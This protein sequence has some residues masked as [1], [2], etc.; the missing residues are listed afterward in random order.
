MYL[1]FCVI[2]Q[3][4]NIIF[5]LE[6]KNVDNKVKLLLCFDFGVFNAHITVHGC[7]V[8]SGSAQKF[9]PLRPAHKPESKIRLGHRQCGSN[10]TKKTAH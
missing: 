2:K 3:K 1:I 7:R 4:Q 10:S 8:H 5:Y 9:L 6:F